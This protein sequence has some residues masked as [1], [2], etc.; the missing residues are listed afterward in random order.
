M[1]IGTRL[2]SLV[3]ASAG[4]TL[5]AFGAAVPTNADT[6]TPAENSGD[7]CEVVEDIVWKATSTIVPGENVKH[8][9]K[10]I[11]HDGD[12]AIDGWW[13]NP[14][15]IDGVG[16]AGID[17]WE[18]AG[19]PNFRVIFGTTVPL[20]DV[21]VDVMM[22]TDG[23]EFDEPGASISPAA[24]ATPERYKKIVLDDLENPVKASESRI[25]W[26]VTESGEMPAVPNANPELAQ[27]S[28]AQFSVRGDLL[29]P[30][31]M[32]EDGVEEIRISM[33]VTAKHTTYAMCED[34]PKDGNVGTCV[35]DWDAAAVTDR[36]LDDYSN[37]GYISAVNDQFGYFKT[38]HWMNGDTLNWRIPVATDYAIEAGS[39]ITVHLGDNWTWDESQQIDDM[40]GREDTREGLGPFFFN[41]FTGEDGYLNVPEGEPT[42]EWADGTLT[43]TLPAMPA[44]SHAMFVLTGTVGEGTDPANTSYRIDADYEGVYTAEALE[45][46]GC[47]ETPSPTPTDTETATSTPTVTSTPTATS[48]ATPTDGPTSEA[49]SDGPTTDAPQPGGPGEDG[50]DPG[51]GDRPGDDPDRD[52]SAGNLPRTGAQALGVAGIGALLVIAGAAAMMVARRREG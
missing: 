4:A 28:S 40:T 48:T 14:Q 24:A 2:R 1:R 19:T 34:G 17:A 3:A 29:D 15:A 27:G 39:R 43:I 44:D 10:E 25:D 45:L 8:L 18:E 12:V 41:T 13:Q 35:V 5:L 49:P 46:M 30:E 47:G 7:V 22:E 23:V 38:H 31:A 20:H 32:D 51:P 37:E 52:D 33:T 9:P 26:G 11:T 6:G 50:T 16:D 21:D 42:Y 36:R